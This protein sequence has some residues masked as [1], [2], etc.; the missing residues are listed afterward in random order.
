MVTQV[1]EGR[2]LFTLL[3]RIWRPLQLNLKLVGFATTH[4]LTFA[5]FNVTMGYL[6]QHF[7]RKIFFLTKLNFT[8]RNI[9]RK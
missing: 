8:K 3:F 7:Q 1:H 9:E 6:E 4:H 5:K 2:G